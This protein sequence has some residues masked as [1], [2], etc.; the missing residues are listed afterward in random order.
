MNDHPQTAQLIRQAAKAS[1]RKY[2]GEP[3]TDYGALDETPR[4][5]RLIAQAERLAGTS[6]FTAYHVGLLEGV[7]RSLFAPPAFETPHDK[8]RRLVRELI[9]ACEAAD[10]PNCDGM[11][12][13]LD[14][15][16][17]AKEAL[18][19]VTWADLDEIHAA[20]VEYEH[21]RSIKERM[22]LQPAL[23]R[24]VNGRGEA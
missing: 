12:M 2:S 16:D 13:V 15:L 21:D 14:R 18:E 24:Y 3:I 20:R 4:A 19:D 7:I 10:A 22:E 17:E 6:K 9:A 11:D 5:E 23:G 1:P 8:L